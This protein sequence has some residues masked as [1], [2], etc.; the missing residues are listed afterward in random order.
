M[1]RRLFGWIAALIGLLLSL[2]AVEL[3]AIAWLMIED[4]RYTPAAELFQRTQNTFVR[5]MTK[6]S[7]CRYIDTLYPHPYLAFVHHAN[8]PC[9]LRN[10]NN[11]GLLND[12]YPVEKRQDRFTILLTGGSIASQLA[13]MSDGD[14]PR[15]L[16]LELNQ[17]Y[18]SP[19]GKPFLVL[20]GGDGA[21]KEPQPFI[22]FALNAQAV[23]AVVTIGG[24]N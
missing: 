2:G 24:M 12:D 15:F 14:A 7:A 20:N 5:D 13:Q 21:W 9:G 10:L 11:I 19:N 17:N 6:G 1:K 23:D 16:E 22:L 18:V 3:M 8:P 4:G